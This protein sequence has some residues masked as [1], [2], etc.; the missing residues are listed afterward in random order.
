LPDEVALSFQCLHSLRVEAD[1]FERVV[2]ELHRDDVAVELD[3]GRESPRV[4]GDLDL[5]SGF[6]EQAAVVDEV[7]NA[8]EAHEP[9]QPLGLGGSHAGR[10]LDPVCEGDHASA[11]QQPCR[12]VDQRGLVLDVAPRVLAPDE[13]GAPGGQS[14]GAGV[15]DEVD[16]PLT[17]PLLVAGLASALDDTL[18]RIDADHAVDAA[19]PDQRAHSGAGEAAQVDAFHAGPDPG[20]GGERERRLQPTDMELL[21][22]DQVRDIA[23]GRAVLGL[24][25]REPDIPQCVHAPSCGHVV[26]PSCPFASVGVYP[27]ISSVQVIN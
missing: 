23:V 6:G 20:P 25:V 17:E 2:G 1:R 4:F 21:A 15:P 16:D 14:G 27:L 12:F 5:E 18:R 9:E 11:A 7:E 8:G 19:E 3:A 24:D 22:H 13:I 26:A 10:A